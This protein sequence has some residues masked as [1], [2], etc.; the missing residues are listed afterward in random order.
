MDERQ[1]QQVRRFNRTVTQ[2]AGALDESYLRR[3]RPLGEARVLHEV[4][5]SGTDVLFLR[6]KLNLDSG[7]LSRMLRSLEAQGLI[8]TRRQSGDG[9][10]R[11][12]KLTAKGRAERAIYDA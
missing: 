6:E 7:Y 3:S 5:P 12:V 10:A 8:Q 9:R 4:G 2:Y 1:I 11:R